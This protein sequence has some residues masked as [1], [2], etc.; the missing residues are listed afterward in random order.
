LVL[1]AL[2]T[3]FSAPQQGEQ[4][5]PVAVTPSAQVLAEARAVA[6]RAPMGPVANPVWRLRATGYNSHVSQTDASPDITAT[7]TRT[8][9]GVIA[10]SRDL[11]DAQ[12]PYGSLVRLR[13]LGN[14]HNGRGAGRFQS[15][16]DGQLFIVEDTMHAR[17]RQQIDVWF[18]D[19]ADA[20]SWGVRA[21]E[22]ELVRYGYTGPELRAQA[23]PA[24]EAFDAAPKLA[25]AD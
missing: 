12:L 3:A 9:F 10:V 25:S 4:G 1:A 19:M 24:F 13:D 15:A 16:L 6:P 2:I 17:K 20:L 8:R 14:Y 18:P 21:V 11:L 5:V 7:G 23:P 22:V